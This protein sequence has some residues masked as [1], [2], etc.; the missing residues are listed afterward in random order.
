MNQIIGQETSVDTIG[1][2]ITIEQIINSNSYSTATVVFVSKYLYPLPYWF[3]K[4]KFGDWGLYLNI[5]F[6][7]KKKAY[8]LTDITAVYRIHKGGIH[9]NLHAS[10]LTLANA[11]KMHIDFY[12]QMKKYLF[13]G[14]YNSLIDQYILERKKIVRKLFAGERKYFDVLKTLWY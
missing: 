7:S 9:G 8:C 2:S 1:G 12:R 13:L 5:L 11:Y 10:N 4:I 6:I 14:D 3:D